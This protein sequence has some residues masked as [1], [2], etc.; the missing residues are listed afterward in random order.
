MIMSLKEFSLRIKLKLTCF[1]TLVGKHC[2]LPSLVTG[3][4]THWVIREHFSIRIPLLNKAVTCPCVVYA[5]A[6][7]RIAL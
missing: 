3:K 6:G 4:N 5:S 2:G 7:Y 1:A